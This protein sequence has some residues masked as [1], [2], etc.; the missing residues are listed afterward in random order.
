MCLVLKLDNGK[1]V[2]IA[3]EQTDRHTESCQHPVPYYIID[4]SAWGIYIYNI[5]IR[6]QSFILS[7]GTARNIYRKYYNFLYFF[8]N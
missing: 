2:S 4:S 3:N 5:E 7:H 6:K 1:G 8:F